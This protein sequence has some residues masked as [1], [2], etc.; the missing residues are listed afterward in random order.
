[1]G[2]TVAYF[3]VLP[4]A[5]ILQ[6]PKQGRHPPWTEITGEVQDYVDGQD[7][8][9]ENDSTEPVVGDRGAIVDLSVSGIGQRPIQ[10]CLDSGHA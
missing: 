2:G 7:S 9:Y 6:S 3:E 4:C 1:V 8:H 10:Q 5:R